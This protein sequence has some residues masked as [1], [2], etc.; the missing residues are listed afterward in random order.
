MHFAKFL[1]CKQDK[2]AKVPRCYDSSVPRDVSDIQRLANLYLSTSNI[3]L[4]RIIYNM[5]DGGDGDCTFFGSQSGSIY[6]KLI[7]FE[8]FFLCWNLDYSFV[9]CMI[10]L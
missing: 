4:S 5:R 2:L 6:H 8:I 1:V 3:S 7:N 10:N 9:I